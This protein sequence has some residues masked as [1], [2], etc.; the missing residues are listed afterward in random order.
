MKELSNVGID[1][2]SNGQNYIKLDSIMLR[3]EFYPFFI[4]ER[5]ELITLI[6]KTRFKKIRGK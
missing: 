5:S 2:P 3:K 1:L 4:T 6:L